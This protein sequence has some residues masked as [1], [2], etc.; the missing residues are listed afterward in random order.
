[1]LRGSKFRGKKY[2]FTNNGSD[3]PFLEGAIVLY[4]TLKYRTFYLEI[5]FLGI[6]PKEIV[7]RSVSSLFPGMLMTG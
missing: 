7:H 1:M 2:S 6:Y 4:I 5:L 3:A